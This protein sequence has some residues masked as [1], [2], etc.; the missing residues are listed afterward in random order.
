[1][2]PILNF[3]FKSEGQ[4]WIERVYCR[5]KSVAVGFMVEDNND[6]INVAEMQDGLAGLSK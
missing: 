6:V 4:A 3:F 1:M 5:K 2:K